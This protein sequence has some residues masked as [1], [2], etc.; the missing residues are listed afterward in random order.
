MC[1]CEVEC[2]LRSSGSE[3][4]EDTRIK[5]DTFV[6]S[7][8]SRAIM[9][10]RVVPRYM[11]LICIL[12]LFTPTSHANRWEAG[13]SGLRSNSTKMLFSDVVGLKETERA[14]CAVKDTYL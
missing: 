1:C 9:S 11:I 5:L 12:I 6:L 10:K 8:L 4:E 13:E 7:L 2:L 3:W 14:L